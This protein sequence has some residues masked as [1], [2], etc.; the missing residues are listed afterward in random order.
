M[1]N[2]VQSSNTGKDVFYDLIAGTSMEIY[3]KNTLHSLALSMISI[4]ES[5]RVVTIRVVMVKVC[6]EVSCLMLMLGVVH[7]TNNAK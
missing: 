5:Q 1:S 3:A 6:L 4:L 7:R 2:F